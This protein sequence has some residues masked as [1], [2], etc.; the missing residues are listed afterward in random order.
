M[1]DRNLMNDLMLR[2][3]RVQQAIREANMDGLLL[4]TDVNIYYLTGQVFNGYYYLPVDD[5][6]VCFVKRPVDFSGERIFFIRK[7]E[8]MPEIFASNGWMLPQCVLLETDMI[9]RKSVV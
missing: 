3:Q 2:R 8:Q 1:I 5:E 7:P 6:P 9:D 4:T